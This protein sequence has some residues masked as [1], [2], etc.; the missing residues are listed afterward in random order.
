[1]KRQGLVGGAIYKI[2]PPILLLSG[3]NVTF[4]GYICDIWWCNV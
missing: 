4:G 2:S 3:Y 1:M